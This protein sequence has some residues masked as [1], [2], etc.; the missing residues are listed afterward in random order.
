MKDMFAHL[1]NFMLGFKP[2]TPRPEF[3]DIPKVKP[4]KIPIIK[5][6]SKALYVELQSSRNPD[7]YIPMDTYYEDVLNIG[8]ILYNPRTQEVMSINFLRISDL[9]IISTIGLTRGLEG[10]RV[11]PFMGTEKLLV[12]PQE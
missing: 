5:D 9:G 4:I 2:E 8:D 10:T 3:D 1:H 11:V 7:D 12:L 6:K